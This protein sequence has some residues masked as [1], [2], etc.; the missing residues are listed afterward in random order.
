V[1]G[2]GFLLLGADV[3]P[4]SANNF[5]ILETSVTIS[6]PRSFIPNSI[7]TENIY[8][9]FDRNGI[10]LGNIGFRTTS[11]NLFFIGLPLH[12]CNAGQANVPTLLTKIFF[13]DFGV[14]P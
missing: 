5:P 13:E 14:T 8:N 6:S 2:N 4:V 10:E 1:I 9:L 3:I 7:I 12:L 11:K